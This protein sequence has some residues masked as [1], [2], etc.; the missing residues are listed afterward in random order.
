[1]ISNTSSI[2]KQQ[3]CSFSC[4]L[5]AEIGVNH[6]GCVNKAMK[7]I[8]S[9]IRCGANAVKFQSF[10]PEELAT[11]LASKAEYQKIGNEKSKNQLGM[12]K[13]LSLSFQET[14]KLKDYCE[15]RNI[16][17]IT[18]PFDFLSLNY[19]SKL[20][21]KMIKIS[22]GDLNNYPF[23]ASVSKLNIPIILSTGMG[24]V[25]EISKAISTIK[26]NG[27]PSYLLLQCTTSY[28]APVGSSNLNAMVSMG[29]CFDCNVGFSDHTIGSV[30]A[31]V[32][33]T[34]GAR[35][36]EKHFTL[37]KNDIGPDHKA[38]ADPSEFSKLVSDVRNAE[39]ALGSSHKAPSDVEKQ[40][41]VFTRK[42]I[43]A[44]ADIK[45]GQLITSKDITF[46]R[47]GTGLNPEFCDLIIGKSARM[48]IPKNTL[49]D[50]SNLA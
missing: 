46:K 44:S 34:L 36:I 25:A 12:L 18:T 23:I 19:C 4:F 29:V 6:N 5:V 49:L 32:S 17:F 30:A 2:F 31:I 42:S 39:K 48:D 35:I 27:N 28:P 16:V 9:A 37:D 38:S 20:G 45:K 41:K 7:L 21:L 1:M 10:I 22:S 33:R 50:F 43:V 40:N 14:L 24:S 13:K 47:P 8:D 11:N 26:D 3:D 15:A